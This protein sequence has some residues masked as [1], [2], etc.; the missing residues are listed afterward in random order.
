MFDYLDTTVL[1][2]TAVTPYHFVRWSDGN[3]QNPRQFVV[4][5]NAVRT[6][7]FGIDTFSV[8]LLVDSISY[9]TCTGFGNYPYGSAASVVA[10]PYSGYQFSHWSDG[11]T[12]NPYT[13]AVINNVQL[14]AYFYANGTPYQDTLVLHDTLY[15]PVYDTTYITLTDTLLLTTTDTLWLR[16][17]IYLPQYIHDTIYITQEGISSANTSNA[18]V[19]VN[20]GQ[21]VVEGASGKAVYMYDINGRLLERRTEN[22]ERRTFNVPASGAYLIKV[23]ELPARKIVVIR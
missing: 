13:F 7:I 10:V 15:V 2:A 3:T 14:T 17:T 22:E 21:I 16:D 11:S 19:Y 20:Q 18:I 9:G 5:N 12:Y 23:G 6:A 1:T 4:T 8:S